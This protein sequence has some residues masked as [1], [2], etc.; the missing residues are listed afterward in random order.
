ML[1]HCSNYAAI[2]TNSHDTK[3]ASVIHQR[4]YTVEVKTWIIKNIGT[5][6]T[7]RFLQIFAGVGALQYIQ[8]ASRSAC[9]LQGLQMSDDVVQMNSMLLAHIHQ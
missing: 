7:F 9:A 4:T 3:N 1:Q 6:H 2:L 5:L 8:D